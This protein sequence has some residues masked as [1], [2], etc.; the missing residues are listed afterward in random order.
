MS[1]FLKSQIFLDVI[2]MTA[3]SRGCISK[4][5]VEAWIVKTFFHKTI[6]NTHTSTIVLS[7]PNR[8]IC[9]QMSWISS[10]DVKNFPLDHFATDTPIGWCRDSSHLSW[11]NKPQH[12]SLNECQL[13]I[14]VKGSQGRARVWKWQD[15]RNASS[16]L[17]PSHSLSTSSPSHHFCLSY[18]SSDD[19]CLGV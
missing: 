19:P 16:A 17:P 9:M 3:D 4:T 6:L 18:F 15:V 1:F 11:Q 14:A 10:P 5:T 7:I 8:C 12:F 2:S 13:C